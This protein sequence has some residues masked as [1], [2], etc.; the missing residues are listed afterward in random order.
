MQGKKGCGI[1][2]PKWRLELEKKKPSRESIFEG[3][4]PKFKETGVVYDGEEGVILD[5]DWGC[6][7][8]CV[9]L[10]EVHEDGGKRLRLMANASQLQNPEDMEELW[11]EFVSQRGLT[12]TKGKTLT[13]QL[14]APLTFA[15]KKKPESE[16]ASFFC[17][18]WGDSLLGKTSAIKTVTPWED[19]TPQSTASA[20]S[21]DSGEDLL[22]NMLKACEDT[23]AWCMTCARLLRHWKC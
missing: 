5:T 11:K 6:P 9:Y 14:G 12:I 13:K 1:F 3:K 10:W 7:T 4:L 21:D 17:A 18:V 16:P 15:V 8:G 2:W 19:K 22:G 20:T 23:E